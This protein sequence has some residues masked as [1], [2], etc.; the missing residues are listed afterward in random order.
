MGAGVSREP[1]PGGLRSNTEGLDP[2]GP[3]HGARRFEVED[4]SPLN[5]G[6]RKKLLAKQ[7]NRASRFF[8][9]ERAEAAR[10]WEP[11]GGACGATRDVRHRQEVGKAT[12]RRTPA[13]F[14][15]RGVGTNAALFWV[16]SE[17]ASLHSRS[18]LMWVNSPIDLQRTRPARTGDEATWR[19]PEPTAANHAGVHTEANTVI[20]T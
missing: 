18:K 16:P 14:R 7:V 11:E 5:K 20:A 19:K 13:A 12:S 15:A 8:G 1:W 4:G 17:G 2:S 10:G 3:K 9:C 6:R